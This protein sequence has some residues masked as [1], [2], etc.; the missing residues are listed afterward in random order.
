MLTWSSG[1]VNAVGVTTGTSYVADSSYRVIATVKAGNGAQTDL[2]DFRLTPQGTALVTAHRKVPADLS[3]L[4]GPAKGAVLASAAQ[5]IDVATGKV[6]FEWNSLDHVPLTESHQPL[7]GGTADTPY[8][9]F[10]INSVALT[11]D[12]DLLISSRNTWT[13]YKVARRS[14]AVRWRLGG[15]KSGF[16]AGPGAAFSWQHDASMPGCHPARPGQRPGRRRGVPGSGQAD[17]L[18]WDPL[19]G[20]AAGLRRRSHSAAPASAAATMTAAGAMIQPG[21]RVP[22][23]CTAAGCPAAAWWAGCAACGPAAGGTPA[24]ANVRVSCGLPRSHPV[25]V[26]GPPKPCW[27]GGV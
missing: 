6:L 15:K 26:R 8:D 16:K 3:A 20:A 18:A 7:R 10:H 11:P 2:H 22:A 21:V 4:G 27:P 12:G 23:R 5:E 19:S 25:T 1:V 13:V 14:G 17:S 24:W 9:Y